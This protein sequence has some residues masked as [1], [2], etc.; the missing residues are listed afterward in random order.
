MNEIRKLIEAIEKIEEIG[1]KPEFNKHGY[2]TLFRDLSITG[3]EGDIFKITAVDYDASV[4]S[5]MAEV[6]GVMIGWYDH[7]RDQSTYIH[8]RD[9]EKILNTVKSKL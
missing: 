1:E 6:D 3:I 5:N 8:I 7:E 9:L 4:P 2:R